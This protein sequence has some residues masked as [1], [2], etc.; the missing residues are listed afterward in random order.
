V[1]AFAA[2]C[3]R[4]TRYHA[5]CAT[6]AQ[7]LCARSLRRSARF[8]CGFAGL[9]RLCEFCVAQIVAPAPIASKA[10][11][12]KI[13]HAS[14]LYWLFCGVSARNRCA[15]RRFGGWRPRFRGFR[16]L[17]RTGYAYALS[18]G[19]GRKPRAW[20]LAQDV[21][22]GVGLRLC[23]W[24]KTRAACER[25]SCAIVRSHPHTSARIPHTGG[26]ASA[27]GLLSPRPARWHIACI[28]AR[29]LR[30]GRATGGRLGHG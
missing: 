26:P 6:G 15:I 1:A 2:H 27:L 25:A 24:P 9:A 22:S 17:L 10:E 4:P 3:I 14:A 18:L 5:P 19:L 12:Q 29:R 16:Y 20:P 11:T 23:P 21:D 7:A 13:P 30:D 8:A 28:Y